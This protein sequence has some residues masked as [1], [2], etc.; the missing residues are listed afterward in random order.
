MKLATR[1]FL[2]CKRTFAWLIVLGS[3]GGYIF[4]IIKLL[5]FSEN[6]KTDQACTSF[7][8]ITIDIEGI[9]AAAS[10]YI[11]VYSTTLTITAANLVLPF[12]FSLIVAREEYSPKTQLMVD[13]SR[14]ITI[15]LSGLVVILVSSIRTNRCWY[16]EDTRATQTFMACDNTN[17]REAGA[18]CSR[19]ICWE[20]TVGVEFYRLTMFDLISQVLVIICID[21]IRL[22]LQSVISV[23][24]LL[25][26]L[27]LELSVAAP[28]LSSMFPNM[29]WI[30]STG[31]N[32]QTILRSNSMF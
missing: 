9:T 8:S 22:I 6:T 5:E 17:F 15:R 11:K 32:W 14:S 18:L 4:S 21:I 1:L 29:S 7:D 24:L 23:L 26:S 16:Y 12:L 28:P 10:C 25:S 2:Y 20:T 13:L 19:K 27:S 30:L 3:I 31:Q